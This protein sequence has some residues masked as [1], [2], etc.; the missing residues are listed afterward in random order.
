MDETIHG[1]TELVFATL[2]QNKVAEV[3]A[4]LPP[5]Y[6]VVSLRDLGYNTE[7]AED[8]D[9]LEENAKQKA[10]FVFDQFGKPCFA[11]DAGLFVDLLDGEPGVKSARY[12]GPGK[13]SADNIKQLLDRL[14]GSK[15]R[16]A[17]FKAV[18]AY[19]DGTSEHLFTGTCP[20]RIADK[21]I[22]D[23]GFGY[24]PVFIPD[25]YN[26]TFGEMPQDVKH[27]ISHR[28]KATEA[29]ITFLSAR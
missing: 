29:F 9:T 12:A 22:G 18:I 26:A 1:M 5:G 4:V 28:T 7:L 19:Y 17:Q 16:T 27:R 21:P 10:R 6:N 3:H 13:S 23:N 25:G 11:E 24:D 15:D 20:G 2:N 8:H 14:V